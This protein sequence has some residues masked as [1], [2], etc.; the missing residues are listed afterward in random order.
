MKLSTFDDLVLLPE[1]EALP[2]HF[3]GRNWRVL[4]GVL[5]IS[6]LISLFGLAHTLD[7]GKPVA[8]ILFL[9]DFAATVALFGS[10]KEPWFE[11]HYQRLQT[12]YLFLQNFAWSP[13]TFGVRQGAEM[14]GLL[15]WFF[16]SL[17]V[18]PADAILLYG[19]YWVVTCLPLGTLGIGTRTEFAAGP[20]AFVVCALVLSFVWTRIAKKRF[21]E[22]W[23]REHHR[24]RERLRMREEIDTARRVQMSMLPQKPPAVE[25]LEFAAASLPATEVGG[26]YYD[27][28]RLAP[29]QVA[30]VIGDVAGHGLASGLLLSG[31]R[32][33]LYI[34]E[35]QL[36]SPALVLERLSPMVRRTTD[37]RMYVTLLE[38]VLDREAATL[39]VASAGHPPLLWRGSDGWEDVGKG[40][41]PLGTFQDAHYEAETRPLSPGDILVLYTDGLLKLRDDAGRE[42]GRDRLVRA[43]DRAGKGARASEIREAALSDLALFRGGAETEDDMTLVVVRVL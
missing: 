2:R 22:K 32:S 7:Q 25:W 4:R 21:L 11:L 39:T 41:P 37:R 40:A 14:A 3:A 5:F 1:S 43:L 23:R 13:G 17:R 20:T 8:F 31:V 10:R 33:C 12:A 18:S 24:A 30:L 9:V 15:P 42:Y 29:S 26:D 19:G 27:Y 16:L 28:F 38:A 6:L 36:A 34:L 35:D